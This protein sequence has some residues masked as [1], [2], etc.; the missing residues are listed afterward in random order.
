[1]TYLLPMPFVPSPGSP[2][3]NKLREELCTTNPAL[4][5]AVSILPEDRE[6]DCYPNVQRKIE[7]NGFGQMQLGWA[8]WQH[9]NLFIEAEHHAVFDPGEGNALVDCTPH[10]LPNG[11][12]CQEILFIPDEN[13]SYDPNTTDLVNNVRV[14]LVSDPRVAEAINLMTEKVALYNSVPG[15][16]VALP[17][18]IVA[19]VMDLERRYTILLSA[20]MQ[21]EQVRS[22]R[23]KIGRNDPCPCRSGKKYKKCHGA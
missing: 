17:P 2:A 9:G 20:A 4:R 11:R 12:L 23:Q 14:P 1:M 21:P 19:K 10:K 7:R 13:A 15:V 8:V 6:K 3:V 18:D 5:I 16:D 22:N